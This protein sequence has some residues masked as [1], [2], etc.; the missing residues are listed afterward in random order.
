MKQKKDVKKNVAIILSVYL[1]AD[2]MF[3]FLVFLTRKSPALIGTAIFVAV[4]ALFFAFL[5]LKNV[6]TQNNSHKYIGAFGLCNS[7]LSIIQCVSIFELTTAERVIAF[8]ILCL[9]VL[10]FVVAF[11]FLKRVR[12]P[13]RFISI[14][15]TNIKLITIISIVML[16]LVDRLLGDKI[17]LMLALIAFSFCGAVFVIPLIK[18]QTHKT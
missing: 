18:G 1:L 8:I 14:I 13:K 16:F 15:T 4:M 12:F 6:I 17:G 5:L 11:A 7:V 9:V 3:G 2:I 10:V